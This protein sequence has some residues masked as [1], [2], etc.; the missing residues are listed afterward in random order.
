MAAENYGLKV[1][2]LSDELLRLFLE[3]KNL[4]FLFYLDEDLITHK[5]FLSFKEYPENTREYIQYILSEK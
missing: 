1:Y 2:T 3:G 4:P 5:V